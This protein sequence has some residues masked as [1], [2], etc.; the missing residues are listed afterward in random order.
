MNVLRWRSARFRSISARIRNTRISTFRLA[1]L[2]SP[3]AEEQ[4][5][6]AGMLI[7][8]GRCDAFYVRINAETTINEKRR[9]LADNRRRMAA[10]KQLHPDLKSWQEQVDSGN[11]IRAGK[12][13]NNYWEHYLSSVTKLIRTSQTVQHLPVAKYFFQKEKDRWHS[14]NSPLSF[15][16]NTLS[17]R[18]VYWGVLYWPMPWWNEVLGYEALDLFFKD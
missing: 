16:F 12:G 5:N 4:R 18:L 1:R 13:Q 8:E 11:A 7:R 10:M 9:I 3:E 6:V 2:D 17:D 15:F 14:F